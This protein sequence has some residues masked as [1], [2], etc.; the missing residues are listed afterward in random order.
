LRGKLTIQNITTNEQLVYHIRA[1]SEDPVSEK[2]LYFKTK[3]CSEEVQKVT[4][5]NPYPEGTSFKVESDLE[6][7]H[8][9]PKIFIDGLSTSTLTMNIESIV[10]SKSVGYLKLT[11]ERGRFFWYTVTIE[12]EDDAIYEDNIELSCVVGE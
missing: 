3:V 1:I 10:A 12:S 9:P 6:E 4:V 5:T 8:V 11:D 2:H 7:L